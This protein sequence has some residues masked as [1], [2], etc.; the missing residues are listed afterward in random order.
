[1]STAASRDLWWLGEK[2]LLSFQH[3]LGKW[4]TAGWA[5][6][7]S[8]VT[9][10]ANVLVLVRFGIHRRPDGAPIAAPVIR[11]LDVTCFRDGAVNGGIMRNLPLA[12]MEAA[13]D[14]RQVPLNPDYYPWHSLERAVPSIYGADPA[15]DA[16]MVF[17]G[18]WEHG[19][20]ELSLTIEVPEGSK[21]PDSFYA[22]VAERYRRLSVQAKRPA[23]ELAIANGVPVTTVHRWVKEARRR[24]L[25]LS[26]QRATLALY[27]GKKE[28][29]SN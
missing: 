21:R 14:M 13:A 10:E 4:S 9:Q 3:R 11:K 22:D 17:P 6:Y 20:E 2:Q 24:G 23:E 12:R 28:S 18:S 29:G 7:F 8:E 1:M 5:A 26:S 25:L 19:N 15:E 16:W 27:E